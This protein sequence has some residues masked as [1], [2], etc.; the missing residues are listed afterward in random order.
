VN[1]AAVR[2]YDDQDNDITAGVLPEMYASSVIISYPMPENQNVIL[3]CV[4]ELAAGDLTAGWYL[5]CSDIYDLPVSHEDT[6]HTFQEALKAFFSVTAHEHYFASE[7][8][9]MCVLCRQEIY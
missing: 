6:Q 4:N 9:T 3:A 5:S 8:D 1:I 2:Y 7:H